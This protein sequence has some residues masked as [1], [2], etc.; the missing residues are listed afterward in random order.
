MSHWLETFGDERWTWTPERCDLPA[1]LARNAVNGAALVRREAFEAV[2]GYDE[3][4]REGCEDWD[5]W[6]RLVESGRSGAIIPE[7]LF[8]YRRRVDSMSRVMLEE[9]AYRRPL[10]AL[11]TKHAASYRQ[12]LIEVILAK[13]REALHLGREIGALEQDRLS[14][15]EPALR[16]AREDV[17]AISA[18]AAKVRAQKER[19]DELAGLRAR[20]ADL[21]A[22]VQ[23][24]RASWSWRISAP[25][26]RVYQL[27][28][29][30]G[31]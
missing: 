15:L 10:D 8:Y 31:R 21:H 24:L 2:G 12:H 27:I 28:L 5:F 19:D 18:K 25:L 22:E 7:V 13:E 29:G 4:M 16:R 17:A 9:S 23:G 30:S 11:V 20:A 1:L 6:L 3:S 26:R 14:V